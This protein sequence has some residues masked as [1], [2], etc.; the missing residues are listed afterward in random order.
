MSKMNDGGPAFPQN[1]PEA[2]TVALAAMPEG[3]TDP[4][5]RDRVY[6]ALKAKLMSGMSLRAWLV[7]Q[8]LGHLAQASLT[9]DTFAKAINQL[10]MPPE[11]VARIACLYADAA[12]AE[13]GVTE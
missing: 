1:G 7:G 12:I 6:L 2:H 11:A 4:D 13:L 10:G 3:I 5:E 9:N 8:V